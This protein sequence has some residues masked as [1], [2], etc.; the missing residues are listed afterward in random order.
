MLTGNWYNLAPANPNAGPTGTQDVVLLSD[1]TVMVQGG[2]NAATTSWYRLS[3]DP[4]GNYQVGSWSSLPSMKTGR[5]FFP[6]ALL[7]D[8]RFF[9][10]GG[11]YSTPYD[12]TNT[13]EIFN[14]A[15]NAW[16]NAASVPTPATDVGNNAP[17]Q[18]QSQ[19]G[20]DPIEVLSDGR[21]LAGYY[22]SATTYL[23][24]PTTNS[25]T[26]TSSGKLHNDKSDEETWVKLPDN[27]ILSY[28]I[29]GSAS[30][31][32]FEGQRY[33]P[34]QD[35]W[36]D[37][38]TLSAA[39]PPSLLSG[40]NQGYE[41][42]PGLLLPDGRVII[43]GANGN[44]AY[45]TPATNTWSAGPKEPTIGNGATQLVAA[46]AP[47]A[48]LPNGNVLVA[49]SP[50]GTLNAKGNYT[51]PNN[52]Y[53]YEFNPTTGQYTDV[54]PAGGISQP[55]YQLKT[56]VLPTGQVMLL[57]EF[58]PVQVYTPSGTPQDAWR[59]AITGVA[60]NGPKSY[61]ITGTQLNG[62]S[63]GASYGDDAEMASNYPI[64]RLVDPLGKVFYVW[65]SNWSSTG[66][67]TGST[68]ETVNFTLP[69]SVGPGAYQLSVIANG[70]A[71]KPVEIVVGSPQDD[72]VSYHAFDI[73]GT[74]FSETVVNGTNSVFFA[75]GLTG[76][77][78]LTGAGDDTVNVEGT[79]STL[80]VTIDGGTGNDSF[81]LGAVYHNLDNLQGA[82]TIKGG[83]GSNGLNVYDQANSAA[84]TYVLNSSGSVSALTR[85][86]AAAVSADAS[87][88]TVNLFGGSGGDTYN[89][90]GIT[91]GA[92]VT[93]TG[94]AKADTFNL[95]PSG[96]NL[97]TLGGGGGLSILGGGGGDTLNI[98]D[99]ARS[100][101]VDYSMGM[102]GS[103]SGLTRTGA[104]LL[105]YDA[106]VKNVVFNGGSGD[107]SYTVAGTLAGTAVSL[108]GGAGKNT[109]IG[110]DGGS[111]WDITGSNAGTM[112]GPAPSSSVAFSGMANLTGGAG[113]D[114][115]QFHTQGSLSGTL[116]GG[117]GSNTLDDSKYAGN[118]VVDL[119]LKS[120]TGVGGQVVNIANVTGNAG[121]DILVGGGVAGG[122]L[123]G[124]TGHNL[125]I[126]GAGATKLYGGSGD[127]ILIAGT[128]NFDTS[129]T[130]LGMIL[131]EW[132]LTTPASQ[133]MK[134]IQTGGGLNG[135]YLLTGAPSGTVTSNLQTNDLTDGNG[136]DWLFLRTAVD[137]RHNKKTSDLITPL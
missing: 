82:V 24:S 16:A 26:T 51:F 107:D 2:Q 129:L 6:S 1:G 122:I 88:T 103:M 15:I 89:V 67:A 31:G 35:K 71:S 39:H 102:S 85:T 115:F 36:V 133:R 136:T 99:Q 49:F 109:L 48:M 20:D 8:G 17:P 62:I 14:P 100:G 44:T 72:T 28:D 47:G 76:V 91:P 46:D 74:D 23:Y 123:K 131:A 41:L 9:V 117:G 128:T 84:V 29:F 66:V 65:T 11:E 106:S 110:P 64:V 12:F 25:W 132:A 32:K 68:P 40:S 38:S 42:G 120:A 30:D 19:F 69:A 134:H 63:E 121:N 4:T 130:A 116:D 137:Q 59:P 104:V 53:I 50:L 60:N 13:A 81:N 112:Q 78:I 98:F 125:I 93:I 52:T 97:D 43:F 77:Y 75:S 79:L 92:T 87:V 27:S 108:K 96:Q 70:I 57:N 3:P 7:P 33:I 124:G 18:P 135:K 55:S 105:S 22:N 127:D 58:G 5:L 90:E 56:L 118:V 114:A 94:G 80:P 54:T 113:A 119:P 101:H 10:V 45:Y 126:A 73:S 86:G 111:V 61:T 37:A 83:S 21:V 95:T 34:S